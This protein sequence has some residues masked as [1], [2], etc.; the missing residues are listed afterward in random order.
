MFSLEHCFKKGKKSR[1][2]PGHQ[3]KSD[4]LGHSMY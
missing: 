2:C 3:E 1:L 4:E